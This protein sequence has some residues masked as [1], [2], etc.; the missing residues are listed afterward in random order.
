MAQHMYF[1][2]NTSVKSEPFQFEF[3]Y[4]DHG[5]TFNSDHGVFSK[6]HVDEGTKVLLDGL[7]MMDIDPTTVLDFGC[8][9]GV[10]SIIMDIGLGYKHVEGIEVNPRAL[11][12]AQANVI[13][14]HS[15]AMLYQSDGFTNVKGCYDLI[16]SNPP[17]RV[18][19][20]TLYQWY[21]QAY[22]HL[23]DNGHLVLVI[24]KQQGALSTM[25]ALKQWYPLVETI[26]RKKGFL[27]IHAKR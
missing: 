10:I 27:V 17:I 6:D 16:I 22:D 18:G 11:A 24:R 13:L 5:Y 26:H 21:Q 1:D 12:L 7:T 19:K 8:G 23:N 14:N 2:D 9:L 15:N 4:L 25:D 20:P 3:E